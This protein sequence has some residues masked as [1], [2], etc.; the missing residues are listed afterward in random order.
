MYKIIWT[1]NKKNFIYEVIYIK[2]CGLLGE[3]LG[4]S[5]SPKIHSMLSREYSYELF[6]CAPG[7][8][9]KFLLNA[10]FFGLN[11]TVPY[12]KSV[13][14]YCSE[15]SEIA[16]K[17]GSVNTIVR[18]ENGILYG[19]NTDYF[20]FKYMLYKNSIDVAG[21]KVLILGSG[22]ASL[23]VKEVLEKS[24]ANVVVISRSG[25]NNYKNIL[26]HNNAKIIVNA[27]PV[28]M[29]PNNGNSP[30]NLDIFSCLEAVL[31]II[32]NPMRTSLMLQAESLGIKNFGGLDMLVA[33]AKRS[34]EIFIGDK[35]DNAIIEKIARKLAISMQNI[36]LIGISGCGKSTIAKLLKVA[37]GRKIIDSEQIAKQKIKNSACNVDTKNSKI[38]F[39]DNESL[40][41]EQLGKK[42]AKII[43]TS[44]GC[45][46]DNKNYL[47]LHQNGIIFWLRRDFNL[48]KNNE[49]NLSKDVLTEREA[50]YYKFADFIIDN[51][52]SPKQTLD[53]I[54]DILERN[55]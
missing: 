23:S 1:G 31:D 32:Y 51:N 45:F 35:I 13:V 9:E 29:F 50:F 15:L 27:T 30:I 22:G 20:G 8:L 53:K 48:I 37:T 46:A 28:G 33:Q 17:I 18:R 43:S 21:K 55:T 26:R 12:K 44:E 36:I 52:G 42:S 49:L 5:Y 10:N 47:F 38:F 25:E 3:K 34:A 7:N 39:R 24:G 6:E 14:K 54:L 2:K 19:D 16:K 4:H 41:L 40:V 11:V